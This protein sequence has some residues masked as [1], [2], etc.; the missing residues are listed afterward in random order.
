LR[1]IFIVHGQ[2]CR[3]MNEV[4]SCYIGNYA[5]TKPPIDA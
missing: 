2:K 5:K 1:A 4:A 3:T